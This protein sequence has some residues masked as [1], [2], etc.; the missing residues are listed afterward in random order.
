MKRK[1]DDGHQGDNVQDGKSASKRLKMAPPNLLLQEAKTLL[2]FTIRCVVTWASPTTELISTEI[3]PLTLDAILDDNKVET[4][5]ASCHPTPGTTYLRCNLEGARD[6]MTNHTRASDL[7]HLVYQT[8]SMRTC[9][10]AETQTACAQATGALDLRREFGPQN[11]FIQGFVQRSME[12]VRDVLFGTTPSTG[13]PVHLKQVE[14]VGYGA[15]PWNPGQP[16]HWRG[17]LD[18]TPGILVCIEPATL[19]DAKTRLDAYSHLLS[20]EYMECWQLMPPLVQLILQF[21]V[22]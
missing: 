15:P 20:R 14:G 3:V 18:A 11:R 19:R 13:L 5:V 1:A 17:T 10:A 2:G 4:L 16:R 21:L 22:L 6:L 7:S 9:L 8:L 12:N